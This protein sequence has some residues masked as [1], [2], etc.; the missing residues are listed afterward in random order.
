M[1]ALLLCCCVQLAMPSPVP[2]TPTATNISDEEEA[3]LTE[4]LRA[5]GVTQLEIEL[6]HREMMSQ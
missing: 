1:A 2:V 3:R 4:F 5:N 6:Y